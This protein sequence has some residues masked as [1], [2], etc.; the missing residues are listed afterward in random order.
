MSLLLLAKKL[1]ARLF[2][3]MPLTL[4][5]LAA[6]IFLLWPRNLSPRR[7]TAGIAL[8]A[9]ATRPHLP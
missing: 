6:G 2:F 7:K 4:L 3:P 5:L 1:F 9:A 8:V